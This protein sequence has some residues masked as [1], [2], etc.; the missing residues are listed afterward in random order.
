MNFNDWQ[1]SNYYAEFIF[2]FCNQC[3]TP[4]KCHSLE[5]PF[6]CPCRLYLWGRFGVPFKGSAG[7]RG[8]VFLAA[9]FYKITLVRLD[10]DNSF[11]YNS[12]VFNLF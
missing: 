10:D 6:L 9:V 8:W 2:I 12:I 1:K 7:H 11:A 3:E 4:L 5:G